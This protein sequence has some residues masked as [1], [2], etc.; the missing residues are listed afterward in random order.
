MQ[1]TLEKWNRRLYHVAELSHQGDQLTK[2]ANMLLL[3]RALE[4]WRRQAQYNA[5]V[6]IIRE[7]GSDRV[8]WNALKIWHQRT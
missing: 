8:K 6:R 1:R 4:A 7:R 2:Q 3:E 5:A